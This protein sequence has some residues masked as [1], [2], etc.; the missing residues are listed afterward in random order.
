MRI[1]LYLN[2]LDEEYQLALYRSVS[3]RARELNIDLLCVQQEQFGEDDSSRGLLPSHSFISADGVILVSSVIADKS[4]VL[5]GEKIKQLFGSIPVI[6]ISIPIEGLPTLLVNMNDSMKALMNHLLTTHHYKKF[7][8]LGGPIGHQDN[9]IRESIF[10]SAIKNAHK[11]DA[12]VSG[13]IIHAE[14]SEYTG[15]TAV[16]Q[17]IASHAD[18]P[19]DV[20]VCAN[21]NMAIGASHSLKTQHDKRWSACAVTGFDDIPSAFLEQPPLTTVR[22][23]TDKMG[24][25][26]VD[27]MYNLIRKK[28]TP[29]IIHIDSTLI[30][31]NSC[32]CV[33]SENFTQKNIQL[34][35]DISTIQR[36]RIK[37]EQMQQHVSF[38]SQTLNSVNSIYDIVENLRSFLGNSGIQTF[39]F[40]LF[41]PD[42]NHILDESLLIYTKT[43]KKETVYTPGKKVS[44]QVFFSKKVKHSTPQDLTLR[45]LC[46]GKEQLGLIV[47]EAESSVHPQMCSLSILLGNT[48][49][50]MHFLQK[51]KERSRELEKEVE[52]RTKQIVDANKKLAQESQRRILVEAEVLK[53]SEQ[54]RMRFSMDLH[55]D[56]CQRLAGISMMCQGMSALQPD[57]A[58]LSTLIDETLR[59]TRQY[60]HDSFPMELDALGMKQA[61]ENLCHTV[62]EQCDNKLKIDFFWNAEEPILLD[63]TQNIDIFRIIQEALHNTVKHSGAS[64]ASVSFTQQDNTLTVCIADNGKGNEALNK[65]PLQLEKALPVANANKRYTGIGLK[66]MYYRADQIGAVCKIHSSPSKGTTVSILVPLC[67]KK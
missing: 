24:S 54:E 59:R 26:A 41:P 52:S 42:K 17:Y 7:L 2:N 36:E 33:K 47:Y 14:F 10:C 66:S 40:F 23:P 3:L 4:T 13:A 16:E 6:S 25:T 12:S 65:N 60:A 21:D 11:K 1:A 9:I 18:S 5:H 57:L 53:I 64:N 49:S 28:P 31:R 58:E 62:Q 27:T 63:R 50:R 38:F 32:G 43:S 46:A 29:E 20:I 56:I 51:E 39:S 8:F 44:L 45:Y 30:L 61:V 19:V 55:D 34:A 35:E 37:N 67:I 15:M 48:I 22:Q